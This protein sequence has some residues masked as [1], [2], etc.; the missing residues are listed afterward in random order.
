MNIYKYNKIA[1]VTEEHT[2]AM[3]EI[4]DVDDTLL[5]TSEELLSY[6]QAEIEEVGKRVYDKV[7]SGYESGVKFWDAPVWTTTKAV[8]ST[9]WKFT[10]VGAVQWAYNKTFGGD[11][12]QPD[13]S[14]TT[15][16]NNPQAVSGLNLSHTNQQLKDALKKASKDISDN[17]TN[18]VAVILLPMPLSLSNK[19][20][21]E[22]EMI[23][24]GWKTMVPDDIGNIGKTVAFSLAAMAASK[25]DV[26]R[27][28]G[29]GAMGLAINPYN[30]MF[31]KGVSFRPFTLSYT[32]SAE[33]ESDSQ[34]IREIIKAFAYYAHPD[35][36]GTKR[37]FKYP[38][39]FKISFVNRNKG[40]STGAVP[41]NPFLFK[42]KPCALTGIDIKYNDEAEWT[43][44]T[45]GAPISVNLVLTFT[46]VNILT[47]KDIENGY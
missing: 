22:W 46:E 20:G 40:I 44:Y 7:V 37:F 12:E 9:A 21:I 32:F 16:T 38:S 4:V 35:F 5:K 29:G 11:T 45:G 10:P 14:S 2:Y 26:L 36:S 42:T 39:L 19:Y 3:F 23:S 1:K 8:A 33:N 30:E 6:A 31:L 18:Q 47:K 24:S 27:S 43:E 34:N 13:N 28:L 25:S 17:Y 41:T 15:S